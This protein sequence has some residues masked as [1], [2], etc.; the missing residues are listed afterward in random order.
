MRDSGLPDVVMPNAQQIPV[1][2]LPDEVILF[3]LPSRYCEIDRMMR[4]GLVACSARADGLGRACR[5]SATTST[6]TSP[7]AISSRT[8]T[9]SAHD[10]HAERRGV[11]RDFAH[12]AVTLCRCMNIPARYCTGYLGDI[13]VPP[14]DAPMDFS[15]W[16]EVYL[17]GQWYTFDARHNTPRIG[18]ILMGR[19]R[20]AADVPLSTSF[21]HDAAHRL[22]GLYRRSGRGVVPSLE[23]RRQGRPQSG[24]W[25]RESASERAVKLHLFRHRRLALL[26]A[27][28]RAD[29]YPS[30]P[31]RVFTTSS[32]GG[33]SDIFMRVLGEAMREAPRPAAD[34]REPARAA[35]AISPRAPAR[36]R[37]PTATPSASSMP[38]TMIYNQFLFKKTAVRSGEAAPRS[39]IC[40]I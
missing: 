7:S 1:E 22:C 37:R 15:A 36:T 33:I 18:R 16:F 3:L 26:A 30:R 35:P 27:R 20:D 8:P 10:V 39:S 6:I 9:K 19:G 11:C 4:S 38:I 2:N 34:H 32:A 14:E 5:R 25:V 29:D 28:P 23:S 31:I 40:F 13:G 12:L 24:P 17:S 21:G